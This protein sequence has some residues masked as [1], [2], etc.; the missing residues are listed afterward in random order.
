MSINNNPLDSKVFQDD[1]DFKTLE[2]I[3]ET[4]DHVTPKKVS[5]QEYNKL[6]GSFLVE[7]WEDKFGKSYDLFLPDDL[8]YWELLHLID[9][10]S[11][12]F[13]IENYTPYDRIFTQTKIMVWVILRWLWN[14]NWEKE[15]R[16]LASKYNISDEFIKRILWQKISFWETRNTLRRVKYNW[17]TWSKEESLTLWFEE[18]KDLF[19]EEFD[20]TFFRKWV[21]MLR[22]WMMTITQAEQEKKI[23]YYEENWY[24]KIIINNWR[25][26]YKKWEEI[27]VINVDTESLDTQE[28]L[29][30]DKIWIDKFKNELEEAR[31]LKNQERVNELVLEATNKI[32]NSL[33]DY[34]YQL[35]QE[36]KWYQPNK[37]T[38]FKEMYCLWYSILWHS[39]LSELW[40]EHNWLTTLNH[41]AL[42]VIISWKSYYFDAT[43][44]NEIKE[45]NYWNQIWKYQEIIVNWKII[46]NFVRWDIESKL[47]WSIFNTKWHTLKQNWENDEALKLYNKAIE[48]NPSNSLNFMNRWNLL[49]AM[50]KYQ[51]S[52]DDS[53]MA[54][55]IY[56]LNKWAHFN[57]WLALYKLWKFDEALK[58]IDEA[59]KIDSKNQEYYEEKWKILREMWKKRIWQIYLFS[60]MIIKWIELIFFKWYEKEKEYIEN[61]VLNKNFEWLRL[62]LLELEQEDN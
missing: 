27:V 12:K 55:K 51:E 56:P 23:K 17:K 36:R 18:L 39:F 48:F 60:S 32:L 40:I 8:V 43:A 30:R 37:I 2:N 42:E 20:L 58:S 33:Y 59:I 3:L 19:W 9:F 52:I 35:V 47:L 57:K 14:E 41:I 54:I 46:W 6:D 15:L 31:N 16:S 62:Y 1:L 29:L 44:T 61:F 25:V 21:N 10:L 13:W 53:N 24:S 34:F 22:L 38:E 50:W 26:V 45:L 11:R 49:L 28:R 7:T 4:L 5:R